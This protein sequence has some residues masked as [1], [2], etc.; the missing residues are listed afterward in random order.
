VKTKTALCLATLVGALQVS[1]AMAQYIETSLEPASPWYAGFG[2]TGIDG[3]I[4]Q[5]T[6]DAI[7]A[8][9]SATLGST[10]TVRDI[11]DRVAGWKLHLG[12]EFNRYLAVE[13]GGSSMGPTSVEYDFRSGF[14]SIGSVR[15]LYSL[16]VGYVDAVF[17]WPA[18]E[19][20]TLF[21]RVGASAGESRVKFEGSP[22]TLLVGSEESD[23]TEVHPHFGGG[24]QYWI[25]RDAAIRV[26]YERWKFPDPL[27]DDQVKVDSLSASL[28]FR[29]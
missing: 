27:S 19:T 4:P 17:K 8:L 26:E 10:G 15:M 5:Q 11:D 20:W 14:V 21:G 28:Q 25:T 6:I 16:N 7:D 12:Y 13:V 9:F 3:S 1:Q 23:E 22:L 2:L 24:A 18:S 29:F